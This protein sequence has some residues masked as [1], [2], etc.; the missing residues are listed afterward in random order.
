MHKFYIYIIFFLLVGCKNEDLILNGYVEADYLYVGPTSAGILDE[1]YV[2]RGD[3]LESDSKL[4]KLDDTELR[5]I[6][7]SMK[8]KILESEINFREQT[9]A[10]LRAKELLST[11][12]MSQSE[13]EIKEANYVTQKS[14]LDISKQ[15]LIAAQK[16]LSD[17]AP[18]TKDKAYV[19]DTFFVPGEFV[20]SGKSVVSLLLPKNIRIRF[21]IPENMLS[22]IE[23]GKVVIISC[24]GCKEKIPAKI[25]YIAKQAEY[26]P[27]VIYSKDSRQKMV[28]M[29][30]AKLDESETCL[31]PGLP[32]DINIKDIEVK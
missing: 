28:F 7:E 25:T 23:L 22:M 15:N 6:V 16:K 1:L 30:E 12:V 24:D 13:F 26:T 2:H 14:Q 3:Y 17:S 10:Y 4:F 19:E 21:F 32:V 8:A 11:N 29:V 31:H 9:K 18:I 27:P 20:Q 5:T